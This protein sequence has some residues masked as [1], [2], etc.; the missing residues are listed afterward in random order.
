MDPNRDPNQAISGFCL[1][2]SVTAGGHRTLGFLSSKLS[3]KVQSVG[4]VSKYTSEWRAVV[5]SK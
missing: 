3:A 1:L 5:S 4:V 2:F